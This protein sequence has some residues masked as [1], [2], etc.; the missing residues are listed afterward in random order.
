M[1]PTNIMGTVSEN[2]AK[3]IAA[4][5]GYYSDD[6]RVIRII[7]YTTMWGGQAYGLEYAHEIG[8]FAPSSHVR[9]P[10]VYWQAE[11][12]EEAQKSGKESEFLA[13]FYKRGF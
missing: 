7:E 2:L 13:K 11:G 9:K 1:S 5:D 4:N 12:L 6:P 10:K 3:E 8:R